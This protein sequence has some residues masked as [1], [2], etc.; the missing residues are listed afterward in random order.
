MATQTTSLDTT[1]KEIVADLSLSI[2]KL[3]SIQANGQNDHPSIRIVE[4]ASSAT[5]PTLDTF[6]ATLED[7]EFGAVKPASSMSIYVFALWA[8]TTLVVNEAPV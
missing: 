2:G 6:G 7:R 8:S 4:Q 3:Y 5:A 1:P